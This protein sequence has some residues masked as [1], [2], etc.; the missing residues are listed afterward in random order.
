MTDKE[1]TF[2]EYLRISQQRK[3][4]EQIITGEFH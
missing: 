1:E 2:K 4:L 3:G